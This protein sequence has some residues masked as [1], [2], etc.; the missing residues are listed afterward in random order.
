MLNSFHIIQLL[1]RVLS[2]L[3]GFLKV[4]NQDFGL[5]LDKIQAQFHKASIYFQ[6]H[7]VFLYKDLA[8]TLFMIIFFLRIQF[9]CGLC[10]QFFLKLFLTFKI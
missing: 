4:V 6:A 9:F 1:C 2:F 8:L 3:F 5:L 7:F 10:S